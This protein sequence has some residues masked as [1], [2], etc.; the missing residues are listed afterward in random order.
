MRRSH[1]RF[2]VETIYTKCHKQLV[3]ILLAERK[4]AGIKQIELAK[5]LGRSQTWVARMENGRRRID[6]VEFLLLAKFIGFNPSKII[7]R[8]SA[9]E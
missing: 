8:L 1:I 7:R 6:V 3:A 4:K 9:F 2:W 5:H